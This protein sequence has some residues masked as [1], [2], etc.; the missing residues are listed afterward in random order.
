M[1]LESIEEENII[2]LPEPNQSTK[3]SISLPK[4]F[5]IKNIK[6]IDDAYK[7]ILELQPLLIN[8][9]NLAFTENNKKAWDIIQKLMYYWNYRDILR[10]ERIQD[11]TPLVEYA[12]RK[13]ILDTQQQTLPNY[14]LECENSFTPERAV[15]ELSEKAL[16]HRINQHPLLERMTQHGLEMQHIKLFL[17]NYYVNNRMFHLFIVALS[18]C[19][20]LERR[21]ELA[22]NFYDEMGSGD[23][24]MA[25][26]EL[27]L[28]NFNNLNRPEVITPLPE[29]LY[30]VNTKTHAAFLSGDYHYG[31]GGFGYI[32]LTMPNQMKKILNGLMKSGLPK[33]DLE[34]WEIHITIDI[35]HGKRWFSEMLQLIET[36][37][38]AKKCLAG[39]ISLLDARATMYDGILQSYDSM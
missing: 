15:Q 36:P 34:F 37:E 3:I 18:L 2:V 38:Q 22:N 1:P 27:F 33:A 10:I 16:S 5:Y 7:K 21:T 14:K 23:S 13:V 6:T 39:G 8:L 30:L 12:L 26:P 24:R 28:K 32:E 9:S 19:S 20:P 17:E 31:M 25:H 11:N 29:S 4:I 35:E